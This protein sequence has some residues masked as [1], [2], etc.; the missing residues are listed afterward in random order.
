MVKKFLAAALLV[1]AVAFAGGTADYAVVPYVAPAMDLAYDIPTY[2]GEG[3]TVIDQL[4]VV[5]DGDRWTTAYANAYFVGDPGCNYA[6]WDH[7]Q[8][9]HTQP[10][11]GDFAYFGLVEYDSFWTCPEEFPNADLDPT[12]DATTFA[13]GSPLQ[14]SMTNK[15]A[16]WYA[17]PE[18]PNADGGT[19]TT[20]RYNVMGF[21]PEGCLPYDTGFPVCCALVIEGDYFYASTGGTPH[22]YSLT[23]PLCWYEIPEPGSLALLALGGL[24]LIRR[25]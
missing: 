3:H 15:E 19:Y 18:E 22:P 17:D 20:A 10:A 13:P 23:I 2:E 12:K 4:T 25:R 1:P 6:F 9:G 11:V 14:S 8:G 16:E 7:P 21:C 24:A 5:D